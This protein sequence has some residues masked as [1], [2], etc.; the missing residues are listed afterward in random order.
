MNYVKFFK[1]YVTLI[2]LNVDNFDTNSDSICLTTPMPP[3][4]FREELSGAFRK[5]LMKVLLVMEK[6][7]EVDWSVNSLFDNQKKL[8]GMIILTKKCPNYE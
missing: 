4:G 5:A 6:I 8:V 1:N 2:F 3:E 7:S